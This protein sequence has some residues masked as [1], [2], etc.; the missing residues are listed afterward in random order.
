MGGL[1]SQT[2]FH[3][4]TNSLY[5]SYFEQIAIMLIIIAVNEMASQKI[6]SINLSFMA[7]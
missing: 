5:F 6:D 2:H 4:S 3:Y 7:K 1:N